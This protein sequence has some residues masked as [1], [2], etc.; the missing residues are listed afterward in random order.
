ML[1]HS[2]KLLSS[3]FNVECWLQSQPSTNSHHCQWEGGLC[4][5]SDYH[6][7]VTVCTIYCLYF[8]TVLGIAV[9]VLFCWI[10]CLKNIPSISLDMPES[11][12]LTNGSLTLGIREPKHQRL[13]L[14]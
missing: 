6:I 5:Y 1:A 2:R 3:Y 8:A 11:A 13:L 10:C 4:G 9:V 12:V 14:W 7:Y